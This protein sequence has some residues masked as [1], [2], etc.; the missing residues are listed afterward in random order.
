MFSTLSLADGPL[1][2]L[3]LQSL[4][5]GPAIVVLSG[6]ETGVGSV[7][8]GNDLTG[9]VHSFLGAG[10]ARVVASQWPVDD[11]ASADLM[12]TFYRALADGDQSSGALAKA[13]RRSI[14]QRQHPF[15]WAA[16]CVHGGP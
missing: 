13:Q 14:A 16:F 9:L 7:S 4:S 15:Y 11:A 8:A 1:A 6:C 10:A 2:L 5:M 12:T 3:D